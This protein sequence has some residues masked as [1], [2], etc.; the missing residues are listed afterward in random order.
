MENPLSQLDKPFALY[1]NNGPEMN[2]RTFVKIFQDNHLIGKDLASTDLDIIFS[3][4]KTKGALK[5]NLQQFKEG[6]RHAAEKKKVDVATLC[7]K[8]AASIG[9]KLHGTKTQHVELHDNKDTYTG[10]YAKGGPTNVDK[11]NNKVSDLSELT[12]RKQANVRGVNKDIK[13]NK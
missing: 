10:V 11:G 9:P 7:E 5:I 8:L 1:T 3:K 13:Q 12:N 6:V 4:I 2:G